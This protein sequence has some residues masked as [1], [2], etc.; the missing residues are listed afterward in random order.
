MPAFTFICN[1]C[2]VTETIV[3]TLD[4]E[5]KVPHCGLCDLDM[6]RMFKFGAV[7]FKGGG[8]GGS[9]Q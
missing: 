3:T 1:E 9:S 2:G 4:E 7:T 5:I 6:K 8:W